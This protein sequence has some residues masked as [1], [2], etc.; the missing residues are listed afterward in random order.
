MPK[1][2]LVGTERVRQLIAVGAVALLVSPFFTW[3]N[4]V[5]LGNLDLFQYLQAGGHGTGLAWAAVAL[6]VVA[7]VFAVTVK[8][9]PVVRIVG[10]LIGALVGLYAGF[11]LANLQHAVNQTHGLAKL[12]WGPWLAFAGC[13]TMV[14][15]GLIPSG[16]SLFGGKSSP[17]PAG[18]G[19]QEEPPSSAPVAK[20]APALAPPPSP[21]P[22]RELPPPPQPPPEPSAA[23]VSA[24]EPRESPLSP[25]NP[26]KRG[27][28]Q[29][30]LWLAGGAVLLIAAG[31][32][33]GVAVSSGGGSANTTRQPVHTGPISL[34]AA[35]QIVKSEGFNEVLSNGFDPSQP[36]QV[37]IGASETG[38]SGVPEQAF[39]FANGH[40]VGNDT[41]DASARVEFVSQQGDTISLRYV[42]Y[43][44]SDP[45]CC[46][47]GGEQVVRF[48]WD[49]SKLVPLDPVPTSEERYA[50][51]LPTQPTSAVQSCPTFTGPND[52]LVHSQDFQVSGVSCDEG[53]SVVVNCNYAN[54]AG[55]DQES[56]I[57]SCARLSDYGALGYHER[58]TSAGAVVT[59]TW[60]D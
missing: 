2:D 42:I 11:G 21:Q 26:G 55:C 25:D 33:I 56:R 50:S 31:V 9:L 32:G 6:G 60:L 30:R 44:P 29:R 24:S 22:R 7:I 10:I 41:P 40:W 28:R 23:K 3:V 14:I 53:E 48:H 18:P 51:P 47:S 58:C 59:I 38:G 37:L 34:A 16:A 17:K 43:T 52:N 15:G 46:P 13:A 20:P 49:G 4:V 45:H 54:G 5:L 8:E 12:S 27:W 57:W 35:S 39:F 1:T 36:V 19:E